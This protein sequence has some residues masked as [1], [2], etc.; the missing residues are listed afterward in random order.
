MSL[1]N[2]DRHFESA[3]LCDFNRSHNI[4]NCPM[5]D[6]GAIGLQKWPQREDPNVVGT[7]GADGMEVITHGLGIKI[8]PRMEPSPPRGVIHTKLHRFFLFT[9]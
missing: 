7:D 3:L 8:Q 2:I 6:N 9:W 4:A 1:K 5:S